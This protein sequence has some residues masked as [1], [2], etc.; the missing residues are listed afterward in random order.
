M[1]Q[2]IAR[3]YASAENAAAAVKGVK[4]FGYGDNEVFVCA[5]SDKASREELVAGIGQAGLSKAESE[6]F[7]GEVAKGRTLVVVHAPFGGGKRATAAL[8]RHNPMASNEAPSPAAKAPMS[9][10]ANFKYDEAAPLSSTMQWRT[11]L[12]DAT[13]LSDY[14]KIP[15]LM[16]FSCSRRFGFNELLEDPAPLSKRFGWP[17]L[18]DNDPTPL[19]TKFK[20]PVLRD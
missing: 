7:A 12:S 2:V 11:L 20:W 1:A 4:A 15:T 8:D 5:P 19:S 16:D 13:P 18:R 10:G 14:F 3:L 6:G 17:L 9:F